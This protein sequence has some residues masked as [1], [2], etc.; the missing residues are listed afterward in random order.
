[1]KTIFVAFPALDDTEVIPT[2]IDAFKKA[3]NPERVFLGVAL[4]YS[5]GKYKSDFKKG[6]KGYE[7]QIRYS[8]T[9]VTAR[10]VFETLGV[11]RGRKLAAE[12]YRDEDYVLQIDSHTLFPEGWD[13]TLI[14][15]HNE[16]TSSLGLSKVLLTGYSGHFHYADEGK[17][18]T[19]TDNGR[20]RYPFIHDE[21]RF[22]AIIPNWWDVPLAID[23]PNKFVPC[24]K[25]NANF[26]FGDASFGKYNGVFEEAVFFEEELLQTINLTSAGFNFV[27]PVSTQP[28]ICHLYSS[29][30]NVY[31]GT[32]AGFHQYMSELVLEVFNKKTDENY[33][34]FIEDP[35]NQDAIK[36]WEKYSKCSLTYGPLRANHIPEYYINHPDSDLKL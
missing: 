1:M 34:S 6:I 30:A 11:G 31:G 2:I 8:T 4:L 9:R 28:L 16:A 36:K 13:E 18:E 35:K 14:Q 10:N 33:L 22:S 19:L 5:T 12:L 25:F 32:R 7:N 15:L 26:A 17:R 23:E 20:L 27:F 3:K 29:H 24:I 21:Q